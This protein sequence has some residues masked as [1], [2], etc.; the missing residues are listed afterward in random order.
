M[1]IKHNSIVLAISLVVAVAIP[2]FYLGHKKKIDYKTFHTTS[3]WGY[4][5]LV[6]ERL[7]IHQECVPA[8]AQKRGFATEGSA[9]AVAR[10]VVHKLENNELPTLTYGELTQVSHN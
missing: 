7:F 8:L 2:F 10:M 6:N 3:G 4:D 9:S 5:I 1:T